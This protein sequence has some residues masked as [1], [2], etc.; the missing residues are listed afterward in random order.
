MSQNSASGLP[1]IRDEMAD[2]EVWEEGK[3]YRA[4]EYYMFWTQQKGFY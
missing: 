4:V 1:Y 3:P 2:M